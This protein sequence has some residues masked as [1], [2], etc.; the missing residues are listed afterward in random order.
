MTALET[1]PGRMTRWEWVVLAAVIALAAVLRLAR[2]DLTEFKADEGRLLT[3]ALE[4]SGGQVAVHG[5]ASSVGFPNAPMSVWLYALPLTLW[6]HPYAATMFTGVLNTLA[7]GG[8]YWI[9][10]R[11]WGVTAALVAA[12]LLAAGPWAILFSRK[13]WAQNL[14]PIF[15]VAWAIGA[16]LAFIEERRPF[17]VLH[18]VSLAVA[19]QIHPAAIGLVP[20]TA[21]CLVVFRRRLA[22]RWLLFGGL[23]VSLTAA[24]FLWYLRGQWRGAGLSIATS[25]TMAEISLDSLRLA[26]AI[27]TGH[28]IEPL[29]AEG[30]ALPAGA[31]IARWLWL[32]LVI[33]GAGIA[34]LGAARDWPRPRSQASLVLLAWFLAP[35]LV[36]VWHRTPV[37]IHYFIAGLPAACLLGGVAFGELYDRWP[38]PVRPL[39]WAGLVLLVGLQLLGWFT[40]MRTVTARPAAG[41]FGVPL[42]T[43]LAAVESARRLATATGA[44][45]VLLAGD[46]ANAATDD[47]PAEFIALLADETVRTVD[48]NAEAVF[49]GASVVV[50]LG[51]AAADGPASTRDLYLA[52]ADEAVT[53]MDGD[54]VRYTVLPLPANA[55][56]LPDVALS[57]PAL[58]ANF[59]R[60]TGHDALQATD[61]GLVW[62][63]F[64]RTA[65]NPDPGDYHLFNHLLDATGERVA[66]A[67][68]AAFAAWQWRGGDTVVSRFILPAVPEAVTP[69]TMRVGMY[70]FPSLQSVPVLDA[71]ANPAGDAIELR[72]DP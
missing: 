14:L 23:L 17:V 28:G 69:L 15:A 29:A 71:A 68:G 10:R 56:P 33:V 67:D 37:Y 45:E 60:I 13:I 35:V 8:V 43:K 39:A 22:W 57:E 62:D 4:T 21:L 3:L 65:D 31:V 20:A 70:H 9:A 58:L 34:A 66:Q 40:L 38:A 61:H 50:L 32:A 49:P 72:P 27:F 16:M 6:R 11:Y 48:L 12:L 51:D 30:F 24:P 53:I 52:A 42:G 41:G 18:L 36:F 2:P 44:A 5:I 54:E 46:G 64:W 19:V 1:R 55:G 7:V 26:L 47:F 59:T 25:Q 63:L